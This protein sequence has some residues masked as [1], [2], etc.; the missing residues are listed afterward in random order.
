[1]LF[2][3][4]GQP[5]RYVL[6]VD[7]GKVGQ[8]ELYAGEEL[9]LRRGSGGEGEIFAQ[10]EGRKFRLRPPE[11]EIAAVA[12][13]D[14]LQHPFLEPLHVWAQGVRHYTFKA[15]LGKGHLALPVKGA[16]ESN[17]RDANQVVGIFR[18]GLREFG[19]GFV[20][21][22]KHDMAEMGYDL[23]G[24]EAYPPSNLRPRRRCRPT[25]SPS[26]S[27]SRGVGGVIEQGEIS[28]GMFRALSILIQVNY[29]QMAG[30]AHCILIDDIG[31]GLDFDRSCKPIRILRDKA[32]AAAFQLVLTTN[33]QF[34]MNHVPL[35]EWSVLQ[36]EG[37]KVRVR[38]Q[39][40][41]PQA[42]A[43]FRF[44]GM[45]NFTFFEMDFVNGPPA[46]GEAVHE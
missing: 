1:M 9:L 38:N 5:L 15:S 29:S 32:H 33:D 16:P 36:R 22:V 21:A 31:E 3:N 25:C 23:E 13:R 20:D 37:G 4:D 14:S 44:V 26:A 41:A 6:R 17:D 18:T 24:V 43:Y 8:E 7:D 30:R 12:R 28:Q 19:Q 40:N 11:N 45:S 39:R 27:A 46:E 2:D 10:L 34:V 42:F 35:E